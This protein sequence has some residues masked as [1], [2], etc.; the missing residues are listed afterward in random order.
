MCWCRQSKWRW[1]FSCCLLLCSIF[2]IRNKT[3]RLVFTILE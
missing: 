1:L 3:R 2:N